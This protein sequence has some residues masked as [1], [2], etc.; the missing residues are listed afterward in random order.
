MS[1]SE[2]DPAMR[3]AHESNLRRRRR[4]TNAARTASTPGDQMFKSKKPEPVV[5]VVVEETPTFVPSY[6]GERGI[7]LDPATIARLEGEKQAQL[8]GLH[9][10]QPKWTK[11]V[12]PKPTTPEIEQAVA[13][14][15]VQV[16][17]SELQGARDVI[18]RLKLE[19][20]ETTRTA[21]L[22]FQTSMA[23]A[24]KTLGDLE[25][26]QARSIDAQTADRL[27]DAV[28]SME[29]SKIPGEVRAARADA[30]TE[31]QDALK[32][33]AAHALK[34]AAQTRVL[35]SQ[36]DQQYGA[37]LERLSEMSRDEF[38]L[39][40]PTTGRAHAIYADLR[41]SLDN[42]QATRESLVNMLAIDRLRID[43]ATGDI[44]GGYEKGLNECFERALRGWDHEAELKF[45]SCVTWLSKANAGA[46]TQ[47]QLIAKGI[48]SRVLMIRELQ[49]P[50]NVA[51]PKY[52]PALLPEASPKQAA[53][54]GMLPTVAVTGS[55]FDAAGGR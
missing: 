48:T 22:K 25:Q 11:T 14:E 53:E 49:D 33:R 31:R 34:T 2:I 16:E 50:A 29:E 40:T 54:M 18:E 32:R 35:L 42:L 46:I 5:E 12:E 13:E 10:E 38:L 1:T 37:E 45:V 19:H 55:P 51:E 28:A 36:F 3:K 26:R 24:L 9:V 41:H 15:I 17:A 20:E 30:A 39:G 4:Q 43:T 47:L 6:P 52:R 27:R 44:L 7:D 23:E 21:E 8:A